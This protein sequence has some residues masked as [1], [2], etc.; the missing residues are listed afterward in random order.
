MEP[1]NAEAATTATEAGSGSE[2]PVTAG[3]E[4]PDIAEET[5]TET[6]VDVVE[7]EAVD[8]SSRSDNF[9]FSVK[10]NVGGT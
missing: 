3:S 10:E 9:A 7:D 5:G 4:K 2:S 6:E 1:P 8:E